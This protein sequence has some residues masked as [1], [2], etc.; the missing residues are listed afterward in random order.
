MLQEYLLVPETIF[1]PK[2]FVGLMSLY[3]S[4]FLRLQ[5]VIPNIERIDGCFRSRVAGDCDLHVEILERSRYTV[6]LSLSYE[7]DEQG[8]TVADPD[9]RVRAYLDGRLAEAMAFAGEH[10][11]AEIRRL[12]RLHRAE[13]DAR[14]R[15]NLILNKWF[16]YLMDQGHL[17]LER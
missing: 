8:E 1:R 5:Q 15:R 12:T 17:I 11:H 6:T 10:R 3:E 16:E 14:W 13:L 4:N 2:S 9:M 7:F